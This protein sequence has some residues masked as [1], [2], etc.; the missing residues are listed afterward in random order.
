[1]KKTVRKK[2]TKKAAKKKTTKKVKKTEPQKA[3]ISY[4]PLAEL[5]TRHFGDHGSTPDRDARVLLYQ[6]I[7]EVGRLIPQIECTAEEQDGEGAEAE[8]YYYTR[9]SEVFELY[10]HAFRIVGLTFMPVGIKSSM[11]GGFYRA[12]VKYEITDIETGYSIFVVS[13]GLGGNGGWSMNTAQTVARKQALLNT[14]GCAYN[15]PESAKKTIKRLARGF[16]VDSCIQIASASDASKEIQDFFGEQLEKKK[17][18]G[19][20]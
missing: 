19:K 17:Q 11:D 7:H 18:T 15:Q 6:K 12:D 9:A 8:T 16:N 4:A 13:S 14:F 5:P 10:G 2:A 20:K 1:M 3:E